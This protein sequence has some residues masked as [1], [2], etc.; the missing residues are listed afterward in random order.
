MGHQLLLNSV[1]AAALLSIGR[2]TLYELVW[3]GQLTAVH[4]GRSL[5][6][7]RAEL[8]AFV[9]RLTERA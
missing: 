5:R 2:T 9:A 7:T 8:E 3:S 6:F 4:I 1:D